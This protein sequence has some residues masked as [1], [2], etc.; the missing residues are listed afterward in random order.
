MLV[1][2]VA[3]GGRQVRGV[4]GSVVGEVVR[5]HCLSISRSTWGCVAEHF[6]ITNN[7]NTENHHLKDV[8]LP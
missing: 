7:A 5:G 6:Y 8:I 2:D 3:D 4:G 1:E